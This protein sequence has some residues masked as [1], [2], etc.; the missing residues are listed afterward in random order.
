MTRIVAGAAI[1]LL[2]S[3]FVTTAVL[4]QDMGEVTVQASRAVVTTV[5]KTSSG[6]PIQDISLSYGVSTK[7]LDLSTPAGATELKKRVNDAATAACNEIKRQ[8]PNAP[9]PTTDIE[10]AKAASDKAMVQANALI[11]AAGKKP[12]Q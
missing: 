6:V 3:T 7:G 12:A 1:V 2:A 9:S 5:G 8:F 11:A 10:C 4:A